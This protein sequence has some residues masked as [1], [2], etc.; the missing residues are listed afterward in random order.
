M[1]TVKRCVGVA[2]VLAALLP[3]PIFAQSGTIELIDVQGLFR[4]SREA[5]LHAFEVK[6]GDPFDEQRIRRQFRKM[7]KLELFDDIKIEAEPGASG[8]TVLV[9]KVV[10]RPVL[11]SVIYEDSKAV[12]RTEIEDRL[13]DL[14]SRLL[15][16]KPIDMGKIFVARSAI[17]DLLGEKGYLQ[18]KVESEVQVVTET[19]RAVE[20]R[21]V[22][23]GKTR[24]KK[25]D[26]QGNELFKDAKLRSQ[27]KLT[28]QRRWYWPWSR[29]N[30][31]HP[32]KW[33]QD[34]AGVRDLYQDAGYLDIDVRPPVITVISKDDKKKKKKSPHGA[35]SG[36]EGPAEEAPPPPQDEEVQQAE[37]A[38]VSQP[39]LSQLSKKKRRKLEKKRLAQEKKARKKERK[40]QSTK[41]FVVLTVPLTEGSQYT[42]GD[43]NFIGNDVFPTELLQALIGLKPEE[44]FRN[45]YL[46]AGIE[47]ITRLYEDRGHLYAQAIRRID[48][49]AG[50]LVADV[51]ITI[52]EDAPYFISRIE[53]TGNTSTK[54]KVLRRELL[55]AEGA[56]F[57]RTR[58]DLSKRRINQLGYFQV[59]EE[60][61]IIPIEEEKRVNV[62]F[63]GEEAS[64]NEIQIGGGYSGIDGAF[65]NGVYSTRNFLGRGQ[66]VSA[67]IQVGGQSSRYQL[68]FQE[69]WFLGRP[70]RA[71]ASIFR[72][73]IDFGATLSSSSNGFGLILGK[74]LGTFGNLNLG[75]NFEDVTSTTVLAPVGGLGGT[76]PQVVVTE[77]QVSSL[78]PVY[79]FSTVNNPYRPTRGR[80]FS[81]SFQV[82][83]GPLG[84]N[85]S[86][87]KP[88]LRYTQYSKAP[89]RG[90]LALHGQVGA[91]RSWADGT[92]LGGSNI[93]DVPRFQRFWLG[94][95]T[96]GPRTF[97][98]RSITPLRYV[99]L[100]EDG[101]I[102]EVLGDPRYKSLDDF[103]T[104][105]GQP[106]V[107][108]VGGD[109]FF[110]V[111]AEYVFPFNEQ[112]E[113]AF[114][115]DAGDS[116]FEDQSL[117][118]DTTRVSAG[119]ELRFHLP[120]FPV[121]LR[122]IY[123][124]P[125]RSFDGDQTS[126]FT[127]SIGR[128]F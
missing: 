126:N 24:I 119:F 112:A 17:R 44:V 85:T 13:R 7:W 99:T 12:T 109:R 36:G 15:L 54:D 116:L 93:N 74:R 23:G 47:R 60:P 66:V 42:V 38:D 84:G 9:I 107:I 123:G 67:A 40:E 96:L 43:I 87:L 103:V 1:R 5:F 37:A 59:K 80:S 81:A 10:E 70:I 90:Y 49:R 91:V 122:L 62:T 39:D 61:T 104:A 27:L 6:E 76:A 21:I 88:I 125:V 53:F 56:L 50:E 92:T 120:I 77:N 127:F 33:D 57:S 83:G 97:E 52:D 121:P 75:Y 71:G 79:Q 108:E 48:R 41:S 86:F 58:L 102:G 94:G 72:R 55:L 45:N 78:T 63:Q 34:V 68:S 16:G 4:M 128:S 19:T 82:A 65:F 98:T 111:Q 73:D 118:F 100:D 18:A 46:D 89:G 114:F 51:E 101:Q 28:Q 69:P 29:K 25:I 30:L 113:L 2:V 35:E 8:G 64:R 31:Y 124:F 26:F 32:G 3:S 106:V 110:L 95:D 22:P 20:F 117:G 11:T 14:D 115:V 105:G